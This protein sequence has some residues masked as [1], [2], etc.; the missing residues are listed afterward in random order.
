MRTF[1]KPICIKSE[2]GNIYI[3]STDNRKEVTLDEL[4]KFKSIFEKEIT[5]KKTANN[6][7]LLLLNKRKKYKL[8]LYSYG[9]NIIINEFLGDSIN[10]ET[11]HGKINITNC[12]FNQTII[13]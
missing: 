9:G 4:K 13:F 8:N 12:I 2:Y 3:K 10:I 6:D 5:I 11:E 7:I 1:Y